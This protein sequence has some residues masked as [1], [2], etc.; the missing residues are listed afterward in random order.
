MGAELMA[1][2]AFDPLALGRALDKISQVEGDAEKA[3]A[4]D[5]KLPEFLDEILNVMSRVFSSHPATEDRIARLRDAYPNAVSREPLNPEE[6][7]F[8]KSACLP[9]QPSH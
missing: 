1:A 8:L 5:S 9:N 2:H 7:Q 3:V 6:W 4:P